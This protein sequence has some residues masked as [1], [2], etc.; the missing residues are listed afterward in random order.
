M[1]E[2][3]SRLFSKVRPLS[4]SK[5]RSRVGKSRRA[6]LMLRISA[7]VQEHPEKSEVG[8]ASDFPPR[9]R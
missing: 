7:T 2:V 3:N 1:G 4:A 6:F 8:R 5:S 9:S